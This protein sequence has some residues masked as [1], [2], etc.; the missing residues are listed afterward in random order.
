MIYWFILLILIILEHVQGLYS[1]FGIFFFL[2]NWALQG[3]HDL[4]KISLFL[5]D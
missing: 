5:H 2:K 3:L 4:K 1:S